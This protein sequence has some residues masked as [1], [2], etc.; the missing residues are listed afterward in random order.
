[1]GRAR[2][3]AEVGVAGGGRSGSGPGEA[4]L[5]AGGGKAGAQQGRGAHKF[6]RDDRNSEERKGFGW[7]GCRFW[8]RG[9]H[10]SLLPRAAAVPRGYEGAGAGALERAATDL[11]K[12]DS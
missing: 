8:L 1:M 5:A 9:G 4:G 12:L 7:D 11:E 10:E 6:L 3:P 2:R